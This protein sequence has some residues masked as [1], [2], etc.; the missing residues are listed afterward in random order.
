MTPEARALFVAACAEHGP[1]IVAQRLG[2][3]NH[4]IVSLVLAGKYPAGT[5]RI[6]KRVL[7]VFTRVACPHLGAQISGDDCRAYAQA[8]LPPLDPP[9]ARHWRACQSCP[10]NPAPDPKG[11]EP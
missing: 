3:K 7:E 6:G 4:T 9:G 2:Y 11:V 1:V 8:P 5:D 10:L